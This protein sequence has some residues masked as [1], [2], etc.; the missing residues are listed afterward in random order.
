MSGKRGYV[1]VYAEVIPP[2]ISSKR[3]PSICLF[4][5]PSH[6]L[7]QYVTHSKGLTAATRQNNLP[8]KCHV[9]QNKSKQLCVYSGCLH[10][11]T[12]FKELGQGFMSPRVVE[13]SQ[14][15]KVSVIPPSQHKKQANWWRFQDTKES[16]SVIQV[17][18]HSALSLMLWMDCQYAQNVKHMVSFLLHCSSSSHPETGWA[19]AAPRYLHR[20]HGSGLPPSK[21]AL[22]PQAKGDSPERVHSNWDGLL[23]GLSGGLSDLSEPNA[24]QQRQLHSGGQQPSGNGHQDSVWSLPHGPGHRW[25]WWVDHF[26]L[27]AIRH[28]ACGWW[29]MRC[30]QH[31][32][33]HNHNWEYTHG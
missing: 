10:F 16:S 4:S 20:V 31:R 15:I 2:S 1:L 5:S 8:P 14:H 9:S 6:V 27:V 11:L 3:S 12:L 25:R 17:A 13:L 7:L 28:C 18:A 29:V 26:C 23:P 32:C 30:W 21:A 19:R 24:H 33:P 22:V